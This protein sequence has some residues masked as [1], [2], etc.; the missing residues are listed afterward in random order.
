MTIAEQILPQ[1]MIAFFDFLNISIVDNSIIFLSL[2]SLIH[3][4]FG[5]LIFYFVRKEKYPLLIVFELLVL[6][7]VFE[8]GISYL[9]P[10]ILK[11]VWQDIVFDI[12]FGMF[13]AFLM[14]LILKL[15]K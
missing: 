6:F 11:E 15:K 10:I 12:I 5:A 14:Y 4:G 3:F 8:F 2:W 9:V 7:E 1:F 13:G